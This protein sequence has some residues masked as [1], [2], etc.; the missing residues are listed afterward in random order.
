MFCGVTS[1]THSNAHILLCV[2]VGMRHEI[3]KNPLGMVRFYL[4][5]GESVTAEAGAM[6]Y[7]RGD[8][9]TET[10]LRKGGF[11]KT[12]KSSMLGGESF[13]V[14][15]FTA[16]GDGCTLGLTGNRLGDLEM[17]AID[18][19][20]IVQS[21]AYVANVGG[22]TLDTKW[23]GFTKG[24]FGTGLFMLK[25]VGAG[26]LFI[27]AFG[28]LVRIDLQAGE[29][30]VVDNYQ[31]VAMSSSLDYRVAKHGSLKTTI[32]GGEALVLE[33]SGTGTVYIQTKNMME[34]ARDMAPFLPKSSGRSG[35]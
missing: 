26:H 32:F 33:I 29:R 18:E 3:L 1:A 13:F 7:M 6:A 5:R 4:D 19:E 21:G 20:Y 8:I 34:F 12:L 27:N 31:L 14:N 28:G 17:I 24:I 35:F 23:Q 22:I 2:K 30:L 10:G 15:T 16:H 9:R 11:F 25:T